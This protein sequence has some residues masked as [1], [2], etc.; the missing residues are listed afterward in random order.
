MDGK[1]HR[2]PLHKHHKDVVG[3]LRRAEGHL[4]STV[5]MIVAGRDCVT[6]AQQLQAVEAAVVNAKRLL[7]QDHID[8]CLSEAAAKPAPDA[9][10]LIDEFKAVAKLL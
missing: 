6:I 3:R 2:H 10:V 1:N 4:R 8:H 5:E 9:K 7:I